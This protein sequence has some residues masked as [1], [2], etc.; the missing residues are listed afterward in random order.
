MP[1]Y[2]PASF[3]DLIAGVFSRETRTIPFH[4]HLPAGVFLG[5]LDGELNVEE[6]EQA[7]A[8][9]TL[10]HICAQQLDELSRSVERE[11]RLLEESV[12]SATLPRFVKR[13]DRIL[14]CELERRAHEE[15]ESTLRSAWQAVVR[16]LRSSSKVRLSYALGAACL[17][18]CLTILLPPAIQHWQ[19]SAVTQEHFAFSL[20]P[21]AVGSGRVEASQLVELLNSPQDRPLGEVAALLI[22]Q[23]RM[24]GT[25][26]WERGAAFAGLRDYTIKRG[27]TWETLAEQHMGSRALWP[28]IVLANAHLSGGGEVPDVGTVIKLPSSL[29]P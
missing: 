11:Q 27:D 15:R 16:L 5:L 18:V 22:G 13:S 6:Q 19:R 9:I 14:D 21:I 1:S 26:L 2:E 7:V 10:C 23:L 20:Q 24:A 28:I 12:A 29:E 8:H 25:P 4:E 17:A 3:E